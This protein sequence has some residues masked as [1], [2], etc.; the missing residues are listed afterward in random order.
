MHLGDFAGVFFKVGDEL[1]RSDFPYTH[2]TFVATRADEL[3]VVGETNGCY[4]VFMGVVDL[5]EGRGA[6][7]L[8]TADFSVR[9]AGDDHFISESRACR[10]HSHC[11]LH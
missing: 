10:K 4:T 6:L 5:P 11:C 8:E 9:P 7:N 2:F 3:H 1:T